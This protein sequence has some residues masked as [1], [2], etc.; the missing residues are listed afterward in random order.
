MR[1][2]YL[3][4]AVVIAIFVGIYSLQKKQTYKE[5]DFVGKWVT[6]RTMT[7]IHL[8]ANGE[9][10]IKQEDDTVLQYGVWRYEPGYLVW[11]NKQGDQF[12]NDRDPVVSVAKDQFQVKE[13]DGSLT[14]F[15]RTD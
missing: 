1:N 6:S 7:P 15:K 10:E 5:S 14:A 3:I 8:Y 13:A 12:I 11:V 2:K 4:I 9:W